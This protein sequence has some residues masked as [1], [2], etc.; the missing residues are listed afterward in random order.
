MEKYGTREVAVLPN[1]DSC[2]LRTNPQHLSYEDEK[3]AFFMRKRSLFIRKRRRAPTETTTNKRRDSMAFY[4][5]CPTPEGFG[6]T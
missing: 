3:V 5:H 1:K 2:H 6:A 4:N